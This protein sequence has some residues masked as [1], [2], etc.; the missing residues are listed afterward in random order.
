MELEVVVC[1]VVGAAE[2]S[3]D[4]CL[5]IIQCG[6]IRRVVFDDKVRDELSQNLRRRK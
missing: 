4:L 5:E 6:E 1:D 2:G 3:D